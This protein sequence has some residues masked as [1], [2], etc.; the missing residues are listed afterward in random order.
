MVDGD[1]EGLSTAKLLFLLG[2]IQADIA[3][4]SK[5]ISYIKE[6]CDK[7]DNRISKLELEVDELQQSQARIQG[8]FKLISIIGTL[9]GIVLG[10]LRILGKL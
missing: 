2:S 8:G 4:L 10:M 6:S 1:G 5:D 3:V 9:I 7:F